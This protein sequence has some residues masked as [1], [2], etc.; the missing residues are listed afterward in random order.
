MNARFKALLQL[1]P[2][3]LFSALAV[4]LLIGIYWYGIIDNKG[5]LPGIGKQAQWQ[6]FNVPGVQPAA[7]TQPVAATG[8]GSRSFANA[9][10]TVLPSVVDISATRIDPVSGPSLAQPQTPGLQFAN[11][12]GNKAM[13]SVG[14]G[15]VV[16]SDGYVITNFH[17]V[18]NAREVWVTL[19]NSDDTTNRFHADVIRLDKQR[20]LALLKIQAGRAIQPAVFGSSE[21]I[22]VGDSVIAV[23]TPFGLSHSVSQGIISSKRNTITIEGQVHKELLQTDAAINQG[24]SGGPLVNRSG[25]VIGI[26]TAI[27][28]PTGSFAGIGFAIPANRVVD[29]LDD[30]MPIPVKRPGQNPG[31]N[32]GQN[33]AVMAPGGALGVNV[34]AQPQRPPASTPTRWLGLDLLPM[35]AALAKK[36]DSP[37]PEGALVQGI[38]PNSPAALAGFVA[39]DQIFKFNGRQIK[40]PQ[41]FLQQLTVGEVEDA[42]VSI[43][44]Q[45][46]R[47]NLLLSLQGTPPSY[48]Q[49]QANVTTGPVAVAV[50]APVVSTPVNPA[51][52]QLEWMGMELVPIDVALRRKKSALVNLSGAWVGEITPGGVAE[53][54]GLL[55]GD[56]IF[57]INNQ[58][59][60]DARSLDQAIKATQGV[61]TILLEVGRNNKRMFATLL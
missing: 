22:L 12:F 34:V 7:W 33:L 2:I 36:I 59:I 43:V 54:S 45:G 4:G 30:V 23:G 61:Q 40:T 37:Y 11:P 13:S 55:A 27:Y 51:L 19:F 38:T 24:N 16:S 56:V 60:M 50:A 18:E 29:F 26:N 1:K 20:E 17:V 58:P 53:T 47:Q 10:F 14:S 41:D 57:T 32:L 6:A 42:R 39:G 5:L 9:A 35:D 8:R 46:K 49:Q 28:T 52:N 3:Y 44:R 15:L 31:A 21:Q 25:E 48:V